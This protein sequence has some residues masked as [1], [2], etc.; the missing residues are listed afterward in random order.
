MQ[1]YLCS[2][3]VFLIR[4][5]DSVLLKIVVLCCSEQPVRFPF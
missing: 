4:D 5:T 1:K 2:V 3:K